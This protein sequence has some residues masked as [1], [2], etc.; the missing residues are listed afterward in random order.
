MRLSRL[1]I[2]APFVPFFIV[3]AYPTI[4]MSKVDSSDM[5]V[6][7]NKSMGVKVKIDVD[8]GKSFE[9]GSIVERDVIYIQ[10]WERSEGVRLSRCS[11]RLSRVIMRA[12]TCGSLTRV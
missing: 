3:L 2:P 4:L 12:T 10:F 7:T 11:V 6:D 5:G 8:V 9:N 1:Y